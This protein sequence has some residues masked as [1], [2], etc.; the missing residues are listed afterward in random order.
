MLAKDEDSSGDSPSVS[1][2]TSDGGVYHYSSGT[3]AGH[4][5]R[6][7]RP[8]SAAQSPDHIFMWGS[9]DWVF[10]ARSSRDQN[11]DDFLKDYLRHVGA[12]APAVSGASPAAPTPSPTVPAGK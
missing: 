7:T 4:I 1:S 6:Y 3:P 9:R 10:L 12:P 8:A 2:G 5:L 11:V